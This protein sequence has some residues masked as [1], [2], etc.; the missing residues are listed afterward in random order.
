MAMICFIIVLAVRDQARRARG[1][2]GAGGEKLKTVLRN[3]KSVNDRT[4]KGA[5]ML[6]IDIRKK[7]IA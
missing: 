2:S 5:P 3:Y 7:G 1:P 4:N 6:W